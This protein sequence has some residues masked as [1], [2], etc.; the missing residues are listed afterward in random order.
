MK[1]G[2]TLI[3]LLVVVLIIGILSAVALPQYEKAVWKARFA[4]VYTVTNAL[5]KALQLYILENGYPSSQIVLGPDDLSVD[6]LSG[7]TYDDKNGRYCSKYIC[8][9]AECAPSFCMWRGDM[10]QNALSPSYQT[11]FTEL[12]GYLHGQNQNWGPKA[13]EWYRTCWWEEGIPTEK[14]GE[15]LCRSTGWQDVGEGF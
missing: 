6:V 5:E 12:F 3:E 7:L 14:I 4:E 9:Q 1:K 10:Y 15:A 2:F 11:Q 13:N 8:Y